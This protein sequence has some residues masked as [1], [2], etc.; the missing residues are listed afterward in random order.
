MRRRNEPERQT[1]WHEHGW[2]AS[3]E[4]HQDDRDAYGE[5]PGQYGGEYDDAERR[6]ARNAYE[7]SERDTSA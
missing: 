3:R 5:Y 2:S 4:R 7:R 1:P 6:F